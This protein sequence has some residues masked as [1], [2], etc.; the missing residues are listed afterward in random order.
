MSLTKRFG[1]TRSRQP[2]P[3]EV[4]DESRALALARAGDFG[5]AEKILLHLISYRGIGPGRRYAK[6]PLA[7]RIRRSRI[8]A[9]GA[10]IFEMRVRRRLS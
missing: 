9:I 2:P 7:K 5:T 1:E 8:R 10:H 3:H 4:L 6:E